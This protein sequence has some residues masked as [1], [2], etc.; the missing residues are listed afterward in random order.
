MNYRLNEFRFDLPTDQ[1]RDTSINILRFETLGTSLVVS[2]SLLNEG[3]T[4]QSN[5]DDQIQRLRQ[6][7]LDLRLHTPQPVKLGADGQLEGIELQSQFT[8]GKEKVYQYQL[9]LLLPGSRKMLAL[10]YVKPQP[11]GEE[12]AAHWAALKQSLDFDNLG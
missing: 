8:K 6:Q 4:L 1:V 12:E 5:F 10:S 7:V 11:L 9:A 3:E 2:R